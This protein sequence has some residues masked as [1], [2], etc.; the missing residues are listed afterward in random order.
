MFRKRPWEITVKDV[1]FKLVIGRGSFGHVWLAMWNGLP[2]AAKTFHIDDSTPINIV[3]V[4]AKEISVLKCVFSC[5]LASGGGVDCVVHL[6]T[7][8]AATRTS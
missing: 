8:D 4:V 1:D 3:D 6:A 7:G 2:V 5:G